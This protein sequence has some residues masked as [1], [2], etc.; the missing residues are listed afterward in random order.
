[1]SLA[2]VP[3]EQ[4]STCANCGAVLV[5]DQRYCLSCGQ[6]V[7]PVRLA[8]LDALTPAVPAAQTAYPA[9][10]TFDMT[11]AGVM[12]PVQT[13]AGGVNG[14]LRRNSGLLTLLIVLV[15]CLLCG[16]LVGHWVSQ[17]KAPTSA[18][19]RIVGLGG[20]G[21]AAPTS[22]GASTASSSGESSEAASSG[23]STKQAK[24]E[25]EIGKH[26]TAAEKAPPKAPVKVG[27][28]KVEKLT[29]STG[30]KHQEEI[31]ALGATP[32]ETG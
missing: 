21:T 2:P 9:P 12:V 29:H 15:L 24:K 14:W 6:P 19:Y 1:M 10:A 3:S 17:S 5:G 31:N 22:T 32:I 20:L 13:Q 28:A 27:H 30:K 4:P 11:G 18:T 8:F 23:T 16:L 7:S 26:E 25:E